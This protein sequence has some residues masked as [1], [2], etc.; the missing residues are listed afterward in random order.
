MGK[1]EKLFNVFSENLQLVASL[2]DFQFEEK[3]RSN[4]YVCPLSF[5]IFA[6]RD[7]GDDLPQILTIEHAPPESAGG[8]GICLTSKKSN[9]YAGGKLD[10]KLIDL[11]KIKEYNAGIKP[12]VTTG[13]VDGVK[14]NMKLDLKR[15]N[16]PAFQFL[17]KN[18]HNGNQRIVDSIK[19]NGTFN[20]T[21]TVPKISRTTGISL[22]KTAYIIAFSQIGYSL[23]FGLKTVVNQS[24]ELLRQQI[25]EPDLD[26]I[27][28]V[29]YLDKGIDDVPNGVHV[30]Y[31]PV[32]CRS[33]FI[34]F[35]LKSVSQ[36]WKY[37]VF[38]PGPDEYGLK[39]YTEILRR[40][41]NKNVPFN[42]KGKQIPRLNIRVLDEVR[43]FYELW[44]ELNGEAVASQK[45]RY[46]D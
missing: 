39:A 10:H 11:I 17:T 20:V 26:I 6:K 3:F 16:K 46:K 9:S 41:S 21:W 2:F 1:H 8:R 30:V 42:F 33:L 45:G 43:Y 32:D 40:T 34:I 7:L 37:G 25:A 31:E 19:A 44:T 28:D 22:L 15:Q 18:W 14:W 24:Y 5:K 38:L 4:S 36:A 27:N 13:Y 29:P 12:L 35:E 23:L